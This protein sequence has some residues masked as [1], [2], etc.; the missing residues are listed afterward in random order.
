ML[1]EREAHTRSG[2]E[3]EPLSTLHTTNAGFTRLLEQFHQTVKKSMIPKL[4][5]VFPG[6]GKRDKD[7]TVFY[8]AYITAI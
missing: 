7:L 5:Q 2:K 4:H 8:K 1:Y 6:G 3:T